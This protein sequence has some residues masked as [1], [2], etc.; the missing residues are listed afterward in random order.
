MTR[1]E[2]SRSRARGG[3]G[4][5]TTDGAAPLHSQHYRDSDTQALTLTGTYGSDT[6][7]RSPRV[8][9]DFL[10]LPHPSD[11]LSPP[12]PAHLV[13]LLIAF[14]LYSLMTVY[15]WF[16]ESYLQLNT[17]PPP[18]IYAWAWGTVLLALFVRLSYDSRTNHSSR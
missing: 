5:A 7:M 15:Q 4:G 16:K 1:V 11:S 9:G 3:R 12:P 6:D 17:P 10:P 13:E 8:A 2:L 18:P 14:F